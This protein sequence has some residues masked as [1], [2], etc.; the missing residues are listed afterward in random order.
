MIACFVNYTSLR[1]LIQSSVSHCYRVRCF[2]SENALSDL[3]YLKTFSNG[4]QLKQSADLCTAPGINNFKYLIIHKST[5]GLYVSNLEFTVFFNRLQTFNPN[6]TVFFE[7]SSFR[8][9]G[10]QFD[11][12]PLIYISRRTN[13]ILIS[14][15]THLLSNLF[16]VV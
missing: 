2:I 12:G 7:G 8:G 5:F 3:R 11:P 1:Q 9:I 10:S 4:K 16:K 14:L 15:Y 6:K 13:P